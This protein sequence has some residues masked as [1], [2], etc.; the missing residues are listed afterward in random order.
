[1]E[2]VCQT[3]TA[4]YNKET[5]AIEVTASCEDGIEKIRANLWRRS[6]TDSK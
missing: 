6:R 2:Q 3:V 4:T 5:Y 1:M